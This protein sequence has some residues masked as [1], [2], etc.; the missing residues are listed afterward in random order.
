MSV[1]CF[2]C[3]RSGV[4]PNDAGGRFPLVVIVIAGIPRPTSGACS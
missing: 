4:S 3:S 1:T 2:R